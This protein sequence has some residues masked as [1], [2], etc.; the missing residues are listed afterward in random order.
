MLHIHSAITHL[1]PPPSLSVFNCNILTNTKLITTIRK[2][3]H[4]KIQGIIILSYHLFYFYCRYQWAVLRAFTNLH[5]ENFQMQRK[6]SWTR[7]LESTISDMGIY[8]LLIKLAKFEM[9]T[10]DRN[11]LSWTLPMFNARRRMLHKVKTPTIITT[12]QHTPYL[13]HPPNTIPPYAGNKISYSEDCL[14][15]TNISE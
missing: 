1:L 14:V 3:F 13:H 11:P 12:L 4:C 8:A 2:D 10:T 15:C 6:L 5:N 9:R 7:Q